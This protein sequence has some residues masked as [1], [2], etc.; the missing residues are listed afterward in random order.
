ML[1]HAWRIGF[2]NVELETD[3]LEA[4]RIVT[5]SS[6]TLS[7][8]LLVEDIM[9]L[10]SRPWNINVFHVDRRKNAVADRLA[11]MSRD[12]AIDESIL[13]R[14]PGEVL[15]LLKQDSFRIQ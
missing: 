14:P 11:T 7:G 12:K 15:D 8:T 2:R 4:F 6:L 1:R 13:D 3:S 5:R 9:D 10:V